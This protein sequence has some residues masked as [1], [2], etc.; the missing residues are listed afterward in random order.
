MLVILKIIDNKVFV[1]DS[2][3]E[4]P[5]GGPV[6]EEFLHSGC[7]QLEVMGKRYD[8]TLTLKRPLDPTNK[9]VQGIY[10]EPLPIRQ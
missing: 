1:V 8:A 3:V 9:R 5:D 7:Y 6:R 10:D 4:N 2:Y